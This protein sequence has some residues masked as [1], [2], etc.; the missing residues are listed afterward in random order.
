MRGIGRQDL[1]RCQPAKKQSHRCRRKIADKDNRN[2]ERKGSFMESG[3]RGERTWETGHWIRDI[4]R[5]LPTEKGERTGNQTAWRWNKW[6]VKKW[7]PCVWASLQEIRQENGSLKGWLLKEKTSC[8]G[9]VQSTNKEE[10]GEWKN[11]VPGKA[12]LIF[13]SFLHLCTEDIWGAW[14]AA[15]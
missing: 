11:Q 7:T 8:L 9:Q 5:A 1:E 15:G 12:F 10:R 6:L 14:V 13:H 2:Q 4:K 3:G